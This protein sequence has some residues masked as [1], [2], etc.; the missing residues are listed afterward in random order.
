MP[1][2][3]SQPNA[4]R[5]TSKAAKAKAAAGRGA[6][7]SSSKKTPAAAAKGGPV[8]LRNLP[9]RAAVVKNSDTIYIFVDRNQLHISTDKPKSATEVMTA[10]GFDDAKEKAVDH[11]IEWIDAGS[12]AAGCGSSSNRATS[13]VCCGITER[14]LKI[15]P[16]RFR[17]SSR[18]TAT[19]L[20][21]SAQ[22]RQPRSNARSHTAVGGQ[23]QRCDCR[24]RSIYTDHGRCVAT[25]AD[26]KA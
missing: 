7:K 12:S 2:K 17:D 3:S 8:A 1:E 22:G 16:V 26:R 5:T 15:P 13:K 23:F 20:G 10:G 21:A 24:R 18:L 9:K 6:A 14:G 4:K 25:R 11:L 19:F